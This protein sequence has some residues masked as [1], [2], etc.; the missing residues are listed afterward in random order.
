VDTENASNIDW[1]KWVVN[2]CNNGL[3]SS[4]D[5][6]TFLTYWNANSKCLGFSGISTWDANTWDPNLGGYTWPKGI[7][8][9]RAMYAY[10]KPWN[11]PGKSQVT[12]G[13]NTQMT[14][15]QVQMGAAAGR[16]DLCK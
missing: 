12:W 2:K 11:S 7:H 6:P 1:D 5:S 4:A 9:S 13:W 3:N 14:W 16:P 15:A 10:G 8:T